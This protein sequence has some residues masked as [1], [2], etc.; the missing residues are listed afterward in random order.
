MHRGIISVNPSISGYEFIGLKEELFNKLA[1]MQ[2]CRGQGVALC[3]QAGKHTSNLPLSHARDNRDRVDR[4]N[5]HGLIKKFPGLQTIIKLMVPTDP[6]VM[7][8]IHRVLTVN[9]DTTLHSILT[10]LNWDEQSS[11]VVIADDNSLF[12]I[13]T[14]RDIDKAKRKR[15]NFKTLHAWEICTQQVVQVPPETSLTQAMDIMNDRVIHHLVVMDKESIRG[16]V[17]SHGIKSYTEK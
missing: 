15:Q 4:I 2:T 8:V 1:G 6:D 17:T 10:W 7:S 5:I 9:V 13:I 11:I 12:G 16:V 3:Q 14:L